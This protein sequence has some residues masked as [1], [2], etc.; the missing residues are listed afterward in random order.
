MIK[1]SIVIVTFNSGRYIKK[2]IDSIKLSR[3][4]RY[5]VIIVDNASEDNTLEI[6]INNFPSV[7]LLKSAKNLGFAGGV[8]LGLKEARGDVIVLLNPDTIV[9]NN[10]LK[11]LINPLEDQSAGVTG[12]KIL[13]PDKKTIQSAGGYI[14]NNGLTHHYGYREKDSKRFNTEKQV[15]YVTGASMAFRKELI[16]EIGYFDPEY[17]P[18]YYEETD[19]CYRVKKKG[20]KIIYVPRSAVIHLESK[21]S[22]LGSYNYFYWFHRNRLRFVLKNYSLSQLIF[23]LIAEIKWFIWIHLKSFLYIFTKRGGKELIKELSALFKAYYYNLILL[24]SIII[25]RIKK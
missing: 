15:D 2:C 8:N 16:N 11:E 23:F 19:F 25:V 22:K 9:T 3:H 14:D 4:E 21:S 24:P 10:W 6:V 5:E 13:Y 20:Y 1:T 12:S 7:K 18:A 17:F